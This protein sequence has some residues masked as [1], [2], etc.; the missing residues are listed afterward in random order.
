MKERDPF[1]GSLF[2]L[3]EQVGAASVELS[4]AVVTGE[5]KRE[6]AT[7]LYAKASSAEILDAV[8]RE[9]RTDPRT[10]FCMHHMRWES[11]VAIYIDGKR[12]LFLCPEE[13]EKRGAWK[14]EGKWPGGK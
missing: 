6:V 5:V 8:A 4:A 2:Q 10:L 1:T 9:K 14:W 3:G 12:A 11:G 7:D 13:A